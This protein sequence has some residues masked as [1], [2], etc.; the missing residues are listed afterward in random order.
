MAQ[1]PPINWNPRI[2][3]RRLYFPPRQQAAREVTPLTQAERDLA[4]LVAPP[5]ANPY[6]VHKKRPKNFRKNQLLEVMRQHYPGED[7][8]QKLKDARKARNKLLK[9]EPPPGYVPRP[10]PVYTEEEEMLRRRHRLKPSVM[11]KP[12]F[13]DLLRRADI[14]GEFFGDDTLQ[15][16]DWKDKTPQR[17]Q[18][19]EYEHM[20]RDFAEMVGLAGFRPEYDRRLLTEASARAAFKENANDYTYTLEDM[21]DDP[22][23][24]GT[25][26]IR[27]KNNRL[28]AA[29]GYRL[30][31][32]SAGQTER[33]VKDIHYYG[34]NPTPAERRAFSKSAFLAAN[35]Y[36]YPKSPLKM[37]GPVVNFITDKLRV[38]D[39]EAPSRDN[40]CYILLIDK[41]AQPFVPRVLYKVSPIAWNC[42]I[43]FI[44]K[45][46]LYYYVFPLFQDSENKAVQAVNAF[47]LDAIIENSALFDDSAQIMNMRNRPLFKMWVAWQW[48]ALF[49]PDVENAILRDKEVQAEI[50]RILNVLTTNT[51]R[52]MLDRITHILNVVCVHMCRINYP[53]INNFFGD[54]AHANTSPLSNFLR[55]IAEEQCMFFRF[56]TQDELENYETLESTNRIITLSITTIKEE[57]VMA[58]HHVQFADD[59]RYYEPKL[60]NVAGGYDDDD[61]DDDGAAPPPPRK[62]TALAAAREQL[63][64]RRTREAAQPR[65][66]PRVK[67]PA[68]QPTTT[69]TSSGENPYYTEIVSSN[70]STAPADEEIMTPRGE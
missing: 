59:S 61:D 8:E 28:I 51:N 44:S 38:N 39:I 5:A 13:M 7:A 16:P 22:N 19:T 69:T 53:V 34:S 60:P 43:K 24:P 48:G 6:L 25:L 29:G 46:F 41:R 52:V 49:S 1:Q 32:A 67:V 11:T 45:L 58:I 10:K 18:P 2:D 15:N 21:D 70:P 3:R 20:A 27:D 23:T 37:L 4:A 14:R 66:H 50:K 47:K 9:L 68:R 17:M 64:L 26:L 35:P 40:P 63:A 56:A 57:E 65:R 36:L 62:P 33:L 30:P 55:W 12:P 31:N 42:I 54:D